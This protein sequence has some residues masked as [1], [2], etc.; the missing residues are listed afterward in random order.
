MPGACFVLLVHATSC[1]CHPP[2]HP[3]PFHQARE[4]LRRKRQEKLSKAARRDRVAALDALL[5]HA[6]LSKSGTR[7]ATLATLEKAYGWPAVWVSGFPWPT[8]L[9]H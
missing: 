2:V 5:L 4:E 7:F 6:D 3:H 8:K 1:A 9:T